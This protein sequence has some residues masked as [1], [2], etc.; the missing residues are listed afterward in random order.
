MKR[1][2]DTANDGKFAISSF[3]IFFIKKQLFWFT[4][5]LVFVPFDNKINS[6][7]FFCDQKIVDARARFGERASDEALIW[8]DS[9]ESFLL[10]ST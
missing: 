1:V 4:A 10:V 3:Q 9:M 7:F 2:L 8:N 5:R 6:D